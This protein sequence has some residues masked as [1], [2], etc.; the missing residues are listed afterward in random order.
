MDTTSFTLTVTPC[1]VSNFGFSTTP[2][3]V[4]YSI[5]D[6][7]YTGN[8][9]GTMNILPAECD[10]QSLVTHTITYVKDGTP[11]SNPNIVQ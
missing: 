4:N 5:G 3:D 11:V 6:T 1:A 2:S 10:D 7:A 8:S 9:F